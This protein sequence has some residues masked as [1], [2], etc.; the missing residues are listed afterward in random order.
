MTKTYMYV[1]VLIAAIGGIVVGTSVASDTTMNTASVLV[2]LMGHVTL[3]V[4]DENGM[5]KQYIESDNAIVNLG[6][7]CISKL[8]FSGTTATGEG[9]CVG[10]ITEPYTTIALGTDGTAA[11]DTQS[12]LGAPV[13]VDI[14]LNPAVG[15]VTWTNATGTGNA[16]SVTITHSFTATGTQSNILETGLFNGTDTD[17][18]GMFARNTFSSVNVAA[19]DVLTVEWTINIGN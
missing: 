1:A 2:P 14:G 17:T 10:A 3:T 18:N 8:L 11:A 4:E 19:D 16:A 13:T 15:A 7:N 9:A 6:E 12:S 5:L